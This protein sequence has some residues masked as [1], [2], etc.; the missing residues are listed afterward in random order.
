MELINE[1]Q[2]RQFYAIEDGDGDDVTMA[3]GKNGIIQN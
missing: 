2:W 3:N 1:H